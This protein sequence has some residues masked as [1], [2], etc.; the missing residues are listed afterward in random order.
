MRIGVK[1]S[2]NED[3]LLQDAN[4]RETH[5]HEKVTFLGHRFRP[6]RARNRRGEG[7]VT[8]LP[9]ISEKAAKGIRQEMRNEIAA[10]PNRSNPIRFGTCEQVYRD[11]SRTPAG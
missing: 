11:E 1:S 3:R 5:K 7:F 4:R 9:T 2:E 6:R 10:L 8:F